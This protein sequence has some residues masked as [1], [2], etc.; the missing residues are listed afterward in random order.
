MGSCDRGRTI[1]HFVYDTSSPCL[2]SAVYIPN[3]TFM[4]LRIAE[5]AAQGIQFCGIV[6]S[7][8]PKQDTLSA[9]DI[10]YIRKVL[11]A[12]PTSVDKLY[13]PIMFPHQTVIPFSAH[14]ETGIIQKEALEVISTSRGGE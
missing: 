9:E 2:D 4:N 7:H 8:P 5:F 1:T 13:F 11:A 3:T 12:M 14:K 10:K 6:H